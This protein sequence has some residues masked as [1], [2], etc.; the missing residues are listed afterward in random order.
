MVEARTIDEKEK[1]N[2]YESG[3]AG[4]IFF[5]AFVIVVMSIFSVFY[6][7]ENKLNYKM[8]N[9]ISSLDDLRRDLKKQVLEMEKEGF[10]DSVNYK[11]AVGVNERLDS[12]RN[13][14]VDIKKIFKNQPWAD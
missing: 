1:K 7:Y 10:S 9:T 11:N 4:L 2:L 6:I 5:I 3:V 14:L 13:E 12:M 8:D